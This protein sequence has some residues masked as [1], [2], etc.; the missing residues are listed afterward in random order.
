M[1]EEDF[2][3]GFELDSELK[4]ASDSKMKDVKVC[5]LDNNDCESCSG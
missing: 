2:D 5:S 3:L 1:N 4:T